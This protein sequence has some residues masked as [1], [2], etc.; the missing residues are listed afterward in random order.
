MVATGTKNVTPDAWGQDDPRSAWFVYVV[1]DG[2]DY[3]K[4]G[5]SKS[6][7]ARLAMLQTGNPCRLHIEAL[8]A[9]VD[10]QGALVIEDALQASL[11]PFAAP[12]GSE[13]YR[14]CD[15]SRSLLADIEAGVSCPTLVVEGEIMPRHIH[16]AFDHVGRLATAAPR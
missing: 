8:F 6:P 4:I 16:K 13:W 14:D 15:G 7:A 10:R 5:M 9:C 11:R 2:G 12:G 1:S 3:L